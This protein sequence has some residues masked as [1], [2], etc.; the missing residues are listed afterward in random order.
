MT[1]STSNTITW[2]RA[3]WLELLLAFALLAMITVSPTSLRAEDSDLPSGE[4]IFDDYLKATGGNK[5][6][7]KLVSRVTVASLDLAAQGIKLNMTI[8]SARPNLNYTVVESEF[9]GKIEKG[10]DGKTVWE[11]SDMMGEQIKD[12]QERTDFLRETNFDRFAAWR[13]LYSEAKCVGIETVDDRPAYKLLLTPV[14]GK[15]QTMYFDTESKLLLK[16]EFVIENAMGSIP[17]TSHVSD[18]RKVDG[19]LMPFKV[20]AVVMDQ[21]RVLVTESVEHNVDL[22]ADRFELPQAI[23][24]LVGE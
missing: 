9:T 13:E 19:V 2:I 15:Q 1:Q 11:M 24:A 4:K 22:P 10:T 17:I 18:Y 8:Y 14:E 20:K 7:K 16:H 5:A 12:G 21:E 3:H 23:Q 6:R